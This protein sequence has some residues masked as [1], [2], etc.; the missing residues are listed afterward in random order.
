M[1]TLLVI[2][3]VTTPDAWIQLSLIDNGNFHT[4]AGMVVDLETTVSN[5]RTLATIGNRV[6]ERW[7]CLTG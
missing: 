2:T 4:K 3:L 7:G 6:C 5:L 1:E